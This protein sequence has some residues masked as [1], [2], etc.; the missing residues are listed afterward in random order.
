M[1]SPHT[2]IECSCS[3]AYGCVQISWWTPPE[4]MHISRYL[5]SSA[6]WTVTVWSTKVRAWPYLSPFVQSRRWR[7]F[8]SDTSAISEDKPS[9]KREA[10]TVR[11]ALKSSIT[12]LNTAGTA[13]AQWLPSEVCYMVSMVYKLCPRMIISRA[14]IYG[15]SG[16]KGTWNPGD[17]S[18]HD[19]TRYL[20]WDVQ[21]LMFSDG[22]LMLDM[23]HAHV[24]VSI[25]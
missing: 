17:D 19:Q 15:Y 7:V 20:W 12:I 24:H 5:Q 4:R 14:P 2:S 1:A 18:I 16:V 3:A 25:I 8:K 10:Q 21:L 11:G 9:P 6:T 23:A 22:W 13:V